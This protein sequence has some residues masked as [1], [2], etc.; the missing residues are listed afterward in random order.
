[1]VYIQCR[2]IAHALVIEIHD[3]TI[4]TR[5]AVAYVDGFTA[6]VHRC[7]E[8][9]GVDGEDIGFTDLALLFDKEDL[10]TVLIIS[11]V[12]DTG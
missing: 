1:M 3:I 8:G 7:F 12:V 2:G 9:C 6:Q 10:L 4:F 11:D 5:A